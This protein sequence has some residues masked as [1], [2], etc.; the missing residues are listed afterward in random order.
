MKLFSLLVSTAIF[1]FFYPQSTEAKASKCYYCNGSC[2]DPLDEQICPTD[3]TYNC[4]SA[5]IPLGKC[6]VGTKIFETFYKFFLDGM[7]FPAKGC[8][9]DNEANKQLCDSFNYIEGGSCRLCD[10][11]LCNAE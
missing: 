11:D 3:G 6:Q 8:F 9:A 5:V 2:N 4:L 7:L 10:T 1:A